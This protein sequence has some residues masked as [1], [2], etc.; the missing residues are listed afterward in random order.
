MHIRT[1]LDI[2]ENIRPQRF[3]CRNLSLAWPRFWDSVRYFH[4][5]LQN[6]DHK[7]S[8]TIMSGKN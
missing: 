6:S 4:A 7:T 2:S 5:V 8:R 3:R 1:Y